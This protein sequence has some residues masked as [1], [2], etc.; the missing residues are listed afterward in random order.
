M[1]NECEDIEVSQQCKG[2]KPSENIWKTKFTLKV[3]R[4]PVETWH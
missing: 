4:E 3:K 1:A 2:W